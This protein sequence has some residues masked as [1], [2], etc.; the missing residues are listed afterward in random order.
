VRADGLTK[1]ALRTVRVP[2]SV[3]AI[4]CLGVDQVDL[5]NVVSLEFDFSEKPTGE[6]EIDSVQFT[7]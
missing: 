3:Y 5:T 7:S 2:L 6:I 1:S 4:K